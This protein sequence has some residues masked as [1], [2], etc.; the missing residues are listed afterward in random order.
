[1]PY[2]V[3]ISDDLEGSTA[4]VLDALR[5]RDHDPQVIEC[6]RISDPA[7]TLTIYGEG[8]NEHAVVRD[9]KLSRDICIDANTRV[10]RRQPTIPTHP[11]PGSADAAVVNFVNQQYRS[12]LNSLFSVPARWMNPVAADRSLDQ[13]KMLGSRIARDVGLP[14]IPTVLTD[15]PRVWQEHVRRFARTGDIAVKPT[16]AWAARL[17]GADK[18]LSIYTVRLDRKS[19]LDLAESVAFAPLLLQPYIEKSYELRV[20]MVGRQAF[21]CRID[22][23]KT[24][25]TSTDWRRYDFVN[26]P[27]RSWRLDVEIAERLADFMECANLTYAA[28]DLIVTPQNDLYFVE[29]NPAGQFGWIEDLT[30]LRI[31]DAIADW[32]LTT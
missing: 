27:H 5:R 24:R 10:L 20:T 2:P 28:I 19:A 30:G 3:I 22:S 11:S 32:L 13:N 12:A 14:T 29:A 1:M 18:T 31:G 21:T 25:R 26:T 4:L 15:S 9:E 8:S 17:L 6:G 7:L 23:Q 16:S